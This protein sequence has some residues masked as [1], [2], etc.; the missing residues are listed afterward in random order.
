MADATDAERLAHSIGAHYDVM[1]IP[2][3]RVDA[4]EL[5]LPIIGRALSMVSIAASNYYLHLHF[6][7]RPDF[8]LEVEGSGSLVSPSNAQQIPV[9][10]R[11]GP[12]SEVTALVGKQVVAAIATR[13]GALRIT[14]EDG[15]EFSVDAPEGYETWQLRDHESM[16]ILVTHAGGGVVQFATP[17]ASLPR[18]TP[19]LPSRL[20]RAKALAK[21][22]LRQ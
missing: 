22:L 18:W 5:Q 7:G 3:F 20:A 13:E 11:S 14:F 10:P 9:A 2:G 12:Y 16:Y 19:V 17:D 21:R 1:P 15:S 8:V 6:W 4:D